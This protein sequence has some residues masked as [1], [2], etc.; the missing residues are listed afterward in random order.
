MGRVDGYREAVQEFYRKYRPL[1]KK[2]GLRMEAHFGNGEDNW[3]KIWEHAWTSKER[4]LCWLKEEESGET[5]YR[6][7]A[8]MLEIFEQRE[9]GQRMKAG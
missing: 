4:L 2:H 1:Q 9:E 5:C 3:L 7:A 8:G 6:K